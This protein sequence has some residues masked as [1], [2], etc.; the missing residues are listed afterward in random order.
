[1]IRLRNELARQRKA[2]ATCPVSTAIFVRIAAQAAIDDLSEG[3][4]IAKVTPFW[5]L[6]T[7][8][9][10]IAKKLTIDSQWIDLQ[11]EL[12]QAG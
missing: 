6:L 2:D 1:M 10:T 8:Q 12:E 4:E 9:D 3:A 7:G 11:R 5:R